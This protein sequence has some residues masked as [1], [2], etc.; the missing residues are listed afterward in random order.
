M[1]CQNLLLSGL[2]SLTLSV[3]ASTMLVAPAVLAQGG[4]PGGGAGGRDPLAIYREAGINADQETSIKDIVK[5]FESANSVR[6][7]KMRNLLNDMRSLSLQPAPEEDK[8]LAK[9][10]EINKVQAE[11]SNERIKLLLKIR[12]VLKDDQKKKLVDLMQKSAQPGV[13]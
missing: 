13:Q 12:A 1:G 2:R 11:V 8:V 10:D 7:D 6:I 4:P 5:E 3:V 9:Q